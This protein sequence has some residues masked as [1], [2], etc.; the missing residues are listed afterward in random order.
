M[1]EINMALLNDFFVEAE[2]HLNEMESLLLQL[3]GDPENIDVLN[4]IFR[5]IHNI[6]GGAQFT[7]LEKIS[8]LSH[9]MEDLLEL[10]RQG[11]LL[12]DESIVE[13]LIAGRDRI[14]RLVSE[15]EASQQEES[16]IDDLVAQ[17]SVQIEGDAKAAAA[18]PP[19]VETQAG[20]MAAAVAET[21]TAES[22]TTADSAT[23]YEEENDQELFGIFIGHLR[24]KLLVLASETEHLKQSTDQQQGLLRC[25]DALK[26][27]RS[28]GNYMGYEGLVH[29]Y[30]A[31]SVALE[32]ALEASIQ[33][34]AVSPAFMDDYLDK[35]ITVFPQLAGV[36]TKQAAGSSAT[37]I[38]S[39]DAGEP[40]ITDE[41]LSAF[42]DEACAQPVD[43]PASDEHDGSANNE[44]AA[45]VASQ[46]E[47]ATHNEEDETDA[48]QGHINLA[49]LGD[50]IIEA[51]EHLDEMEALLLQ[52]V[53]DPQSLELLN[54][55]FRTVHNIKGGAQ[56]TGLAKISAL[57]HRME[58]L[59]DLLR[60][61]QLDSD[62]SIVEKLI[63]GRD[64]IVRLVAELETSKCEQSS[65]S[66]LVSELSSFIE[67]DVS[68]ENDKSAPAK[69]SVNPVDPLPN[70]I[71]HVDYQEEYD[72]ELFGIFIQHLQEQ[73]SV[74]I[75]ELER[76]KH[77][78]DHAEGIAS[79]RDALKRLR[80]SANYMDYQ[81]LTSF[82]DTWIATLEQVQRDSGHGEPATL[83]FMHDCVDELFGAFPQLKEIEPVARP[84]EQSAKQSMEQPVKQAVAVPVA[85]TRV[86]VASD[87][88]AKSIG[89]AQ[90]VVLPIENVKKDEQALFDQLNNAL[91][92]SM[93]AVSNGE[94]AAIDSVFDQM[95]SG[96]TGE[97]RV[98]DNQQA[99]AANL[100]AGA[101]QQKPK[102]KPT[103]K[104]ASSTNDV[105]NSKVSSKANSHESSRQ[106]SQQNSRQNKENNQKDGTAK[107]D[108][109]RDKKFKKSVRVDADKIDSLINQVGEL[110]VDRSYFFQLFN[111]MRDLQK[112]LKEKSGMG[113]R[114]VKMVRSFTYKLG[115]AI[116]A[117]GRTSN[118]LQEGVMKMRMF[119]ISHI[120]SRYPRLVHDLTR[121][122]DKK[123]NLVIR[124]ED[125]ELDKMI[126]E[127]LSDP[128]IHIIRNAVDHGMETTQE[129]KRS[130]KPEIGTL[131]LDAYQES[132]HIVIEV[133]DDGRGIDLEK[134]KAKALSKGLYTTEELQR[135]NNRDLTHL[136]LAPGFSTAEKI[137][138]TSGRGVGM[139]IV[140]RNIEKLN[141]LLEINSKPG[142]GTQMRLKIPLTLAI[143]HALMIR[144]GKDMFA[145]P[146]A[147]VD[148]TVRIKNS[149]TSMMEGVEVIH[150]REDALPIFRLSTLFDIPAD[151]NSGKSFVVI[152][153]IE[154][155]RTGFMVDELKGQQEVVI[156]PLAD[157]VQDKSGFSGATIIGDGRI[158]LILDVYELVKMTSKIQ[159]RRHK[160]RSA[161]VKSSIF[162]RQKPGAQPSAGGV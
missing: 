140:K 74:V 82:Y 39:E 49:L 123:V 7:G 80:S 25:I 35:M 153:S 125:T 56:F 64:L 52:L 142:A 26:R 36:V 41:V 92:S 4:D 152:V 20:E 75:A 13:L 5:T 42:S 45:P 90:A 137:T 87:S 66:E 73:Y 86:A 100:T 110:V 158:S 59:L 148:E 37:G 132:N 27:L 9:R 95:V 156:K 109:S 103:A 38:G 17:L 65:V 122:I 85:D 50:F 146:L 62:N 61:G 155:K 97:M 57:S 1:T 29:I 12:S 11:E 31:W 94:Y 115:E 22:T 138:G 144:I 19:Q 129:R 71:G 126:V 40:D 48:A 147:N 116:T 34:E 154:G 160:K 161:A 10:L 149:D 6:K 91:S 143:I 32:E 55:I 113:Q 107:Q 54:D 99:P 101:K 136:I 131:I 47:P 58:D 133:T 93:Q 108:S 162:Q 150:L 135:M 24:D 14:V 2:E 139:D 21:T 76:F 89:Q 67:G 79:C 81:E 111:E 120:F 23:D 151:E 114:E 159:I 51:E 98:V 130:G 68:I 46:A 43:E 28:S 118:D 127:E 83:A 121:N 128:L 104:Q 124:G 70:T 88:D 105:A 134:V 157:Y 44:A 15:L 72:Q 141:G 96:Q 53:D 60:Q 63:A 8:S 30:E 69:A 145:I 106:N 119:P 77:T 112:H 117:L 33:G 78:T 102:K 18:E 16:S 3:V 84:L